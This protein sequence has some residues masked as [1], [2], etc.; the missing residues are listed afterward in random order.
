MKRLLLFVLL[1]FG[2]FPSQLSA[3]EN[4]GNTLNLGVGV[5][6]Y[7]GYYRYAGR[8]LATFHINYE[9]NVAPSFTL[10]PFA[11][12]YSF[13]SRY[14][15][16]NS[17]NPHRY[18]GY[19]ETVIPIGLKGT[20]YFDEILVAGSKWD[21]YLAGSIGFAIINSHWD[22]G[23]EGDKNYYHS[24]TPLLLDIHMGMEYHFNNRIGM[25]LDLSSGMSTI[26]LAVHSK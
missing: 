4:F 14:Y 8:S 2:L 18:Y 1:L 25:F 11:S 10:A 15:W 13:S 7:G 22:D 5:A 6:G 23:Y 9:L 16:G 17:N 12:F 19:R 3:Q 21:F 20:F 24:G 26:G